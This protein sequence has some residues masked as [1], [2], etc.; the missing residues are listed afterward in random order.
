LILS[1]TA[2]IR[3]SVY[4]SELSGHLI[5]IEYICYG[6]CEAW[7]CGFLLL[8]AKNAVHR[9]PDRSPLVMINVDPAVKNNRATGTNGVYLGNELAL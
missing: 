4:Q 3:P 6:I 9:G 2:A 7:F 1:S 8:G 5:D